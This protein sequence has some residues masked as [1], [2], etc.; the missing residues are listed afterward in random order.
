M[1]DRFPPEV[2]CELDGWVLFWAELG[3]APGDPAALDAVRSRAAATARE[4]LRLETLREHAT[5]AAVRRLFRASGCDP[6]R[7]R[8]ASE[9]LLRRVLKG[10][11]IPPIHPFV[12]V[13]N[14]V[15]AELAVPVCVADAARVE[16]PL[17]WRAGRAGETMLSLKG[18]FNLEGKPLL[19]DARGPA[20]VP[21]TGAER[22]KVTPATAR[23]WLIAY[24]PAGVVD[25][26]RARAALEAVVEVAP[27]V[28]IRGAGA[29]PP[30]G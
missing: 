4:H 3:P 14:C 8:P 25:A 21:I 18:P 12:D 23:A 30:D 22:V 28:A 9:A 1:D 17:V 6:T 11:E 27:V 24:L 16:P 15:S 19:L 2:T 20:D 10:E 13:G 7:Y 5:V 26:A 29:T